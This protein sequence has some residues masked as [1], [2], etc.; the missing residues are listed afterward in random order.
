MRTRRVSTPLVVKL[1]LAAVLVGAPTWWLAQRQDRAGNEKRLSAIASTIAGRD[2]RVRCPGVGGR[3]L[4]WDTVE[5]SVRFDESGKP[6][7]ETDIR[8][9]ACAELDALAEGRRAEALAC[10]PGPACGDLALAVDVLAHE[11]YHL[12]GIID[13]AQT[14][15]RAAQ[16]LSWTAQQLGAT[17]EQGAALTAR[18]LETGYPRLPERYRGTCELPGTSNSAG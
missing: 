10:G 9:F 3:V 18:Y 1:A 12:S 11:S 8:A 7:D 4:S 16:T 2:V 13:E 6:A 17:P 5:G 15:C 14:E